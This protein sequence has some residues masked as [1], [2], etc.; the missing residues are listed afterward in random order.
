MTQTRS[1]ARVAARGIYSK[2]SH[3]LTMFT[4]KG[5][6]QTASTMREKQ[7]RDVEDSVSESKAAEAGR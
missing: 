1:T 4:P 7:A 6:G 3:N 5:T 2:Q